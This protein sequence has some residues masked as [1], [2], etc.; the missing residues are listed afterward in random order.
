MQN[1]ITA[2]AYADAGT[3]PAGSD[4]STN[5]R[6]LWA[7]VYRS[8]F[9]ILAIL[10]AC[11]VAALI[12]NLLATPLYEGT[13]TVE[14]RQEAA[15]VLGTEADQ[16]SAAS[17]LDTERFLKTQVD[18]VRSRAVAQ[19]VAQSLG[20]MRGDDFLDTMR[21][22]K[23]ARVSDKIKISPAEMQRERVIKALQDHLDVKYTGETRIIELTFTSPNA[24][25]SAQ[26]A[27][28][29][30]DA[31]IR[32]N[33][34]RKSSSSA[35]A[36]DFLRGQLN[37]AQAR[38]E[39]AEQA[40]IDYAR[41][42]RI[43]DASNAAASSDNA[44]T[45]SARIQSLVTAQLVQLNRA[46][47]DA[48][49]ARISAEQKWRSVEALPL[50]SIPDVLTNQAIQGLIAQRAEAEAERKS[51]LATKREDYPTVQAAS[52]KMRELDG[53]IASLARS[54]R[55]SIR[56]EYQVAQANEQK[57]QDQINQL[58]TSTL[59]EQNQGIELSILRR[60]AD[61][62]RQQYEALLRR[63]NELNAESGIQTNNLSVVDRAFVPF[64]PSWPKLP[65]SIVLGLIV[66]ILISGGYILLR[67]Q[68]IMVIRTPDDVRTKLGMS[69]L[70]VAPRSDTIDAD[71]ADPKSPLSDA[72]N[73]I[74]TS[75]TLSSEHGT[76]STLVLT[77]A[78][79]SEGKSVTSLALA[80]SLS[81]LDK[82][83]IIIDADLRRPNL[84]RLVKLANDRGMSG[85]LAGQLPLDQA[86]QTVMGG[87]ID[88]ILGGEIPPNPTELINGD[89]MVRVLAE[90]Q[91]R[92]DVVIIDSAPVLGLA[93]AVILSSLAQA[94]LLVIES[95]RNS[96][97]GM[98]SV[99]DRLRF[100]DG[101]IVGTVLTKFDPG[102]LGYG[103]GTD[104]GYS[105]AYTSEG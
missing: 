4:S 62:S 1:M 94:T 57:L 69:L 22:D 18:I 42:T 79:A 82:R 71:L 3:A 67:E 37:E 21:V 52:S 95:G 41:R 7:V 75:L 29:Y 92:Y 33:L 19:A 38:L 78:Q 77:S 64:K 100:S 16:E 80:L 25:L 47:S 98:K 60:E 36:L 51:L 12:L 8:R 68:I 81:R 35:Y 2:E 65:L 54:I 50:M 70:G 89:Q 32:N 17:K 6:D 73:S 11:V 59:T 45:N 13:A 24:D 30:A 53:Q 40:A 39:R 83:V 97:K 48:V 20:L 27:N 103:V 5:L 99:L 76:P 63:Y 9:Q 74:R 96:P 55:N 23:D 72:Y 34:A 46:Y 31:F 14:V 66:G 88:A 58:K 87:Q 90:L 26:V 91:K 84:H 44:G 86:I 85:V 43:V 61:T 56:S 102:K 104:Y 93:D 28:A 105:Y 10:A 49:T 15:K 101:K